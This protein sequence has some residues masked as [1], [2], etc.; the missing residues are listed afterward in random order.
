MNNE[1]HRCL[2]YDAKRCI[3][4]E[5]F[6][7]TSKASTLVKGQNDFVDY[8]SEMIVKPQI[9]WKP[10][11]EAGAKEVDEIIPYDSKDYY[12]LDKNWERVNY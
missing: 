12:L 5:D 11:I 7:D 1:E 3:V 6:I 4:Y 10:R 9:A 8:R 2:V